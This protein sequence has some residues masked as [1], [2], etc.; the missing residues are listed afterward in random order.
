MRKG[1]SDPRIAASRQTASH[2]MGLFIDLKEIPSNLT[3]VGWK[4][5]LGVAMDLERV[6]LRHAAERRAGLRAY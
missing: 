5:A 4:A 3:S 6:R 2:N 1:F